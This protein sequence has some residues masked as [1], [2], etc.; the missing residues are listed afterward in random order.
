MLKSALAFL[1]L[2]A[3]ALMAPAHA[4]LTDAQKMERNK[5][6][7]VEFYNAVLNEKNYDKA[8]TYVGAT[9]IQHNP[10]GADGLDGI[11][12]FINFLRD[13]FPNNKS[14]IK[15]VFAEGNYVIVHVHAVREPGQR[16]NAIFD[17]FR[18]DDNGKVLEHWDAVQPI[19][20]PANALNKNGM[21]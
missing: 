15:R 3:F 9:Y 20:D 8:A 13:K 1:I 7:V 17:L 12:G 16:G 18:L 11:K 10:V 21:F 6:N 4:Q 2:A 5:K 14:E 19:P